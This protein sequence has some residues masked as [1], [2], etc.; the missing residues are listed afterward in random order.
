MVGGVPVDGVLPPV[1]VVVPPPDEDPVVDPPVVVEP[2]PD[3]VPFTATETVC[4]VVP[5][6]P[7]HDRSYVLFAVIPEIVSEPSIDF[8]PA[9]PPF[10][11]HELAL[12]ETQFKTMAPP[13]MIEFEFA[14]KVMLGGAVVVVPLC[15]VAET[16]AVC[17]LLFPA[18]S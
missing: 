3:E 16:P 8:E 4:V 13:E 7:V 1:V 9:H 18:P 12:T 5:P 10:A 11:V 17:A 2:V 15:V 14:A 6:V